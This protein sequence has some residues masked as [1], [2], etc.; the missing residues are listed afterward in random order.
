MVDIQEN[1]K[2]VQ[3]RVATAAERAGRRPAE[4]QIVAVSKTVSVNRIREAVR[5]GV[6]ILGEN[7]VQEAW[8]K[9]QHL[10]NL[11]TW[12]LVGHLQTNKV[13][14][15]LQIFQMIHSVDSVHLA[16]ELNRRCEQLQRTVEVLVEVKTSDEVTKFG[17]APEKAAELVSRI[18]ELSN[19]QLKGLMTLGK[20]TSDEIEVRKCFQLL[21]RVRDQL[22]GM[23]I[24]GVSLHHLSMGMSA[25]FEW[26]IEEGATIVRIGTAIFGP[27]KD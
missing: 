16:E 14:R 21:V 22:K 25:D 3:E 17:I 5:A 27:R 1:W 23:H 20:W 12:H 10:G 4:V 15:A 11:A 7:R 13:K 26:A 24:P 9:Y 18:S 8:Q 6:K 2:R 19:L